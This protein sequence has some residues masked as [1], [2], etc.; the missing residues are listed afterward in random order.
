MNR[1][2]LLLNKTWRQLLFGAGCLFFVIGVVGL[3]LPLL[4]GTVFLILSAACFSR[5]SPRFERW[6]VTHPKYGPSII[7]WR[8]TGTIPRRAKYIAISAMA[9]SF[10]LTWFSGA[11]PIALWSAGIALSASAL[12]V[13]TR[14]S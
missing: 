10:V 4:P 3:V 5:S 1:F 14:P 2:R 13:G 9:F 8:E 12:Y 7:A 11:P 6:L